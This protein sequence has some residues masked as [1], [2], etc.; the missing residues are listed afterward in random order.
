MALHLREFID[1][2]HEIPGDVTAQTGSEAW[3][4]SPDGRRTVHTTDRYV[5]DVDLF[6]PEPKWEIRSEIPSLL[7]LDHQS[8]LA[9]PWTDGWIMLAAEGLGLVIDST[10]EVRTEIGLPGRLGGLDVLGDLLAVT[11]SLGDHL[12]IYRLDPRQARAVT[13]VDPVREAAEVVP[14]A[15]QLEHVLLGQTGVQVFTAHGKFAHSCRLPARGQLA[16]MSATQ[17]VR[18]SGQVSDD[19]MWVRAGG[20]ALAVEAGFTS[21]LLDLERGSF[22]PHPLLP[23][24]VNAAALGSYRHV[25][26]SCSLKTVAAISAAA[27]TEWGTL[28]RVSGA[29]ESLLA[30][31][32]RGHGEVWVVTTHRTARIDAARLADHLRHTRWDRLHKVLLGSA[33]A[34]VHGLSLLSLQQGRG[35]WLRR[36]FQ[37]WIRAGEGTPVVS[38]LQWRGV[39]PEKFLELIDPLLEAASSSDVGEWAAVLEQLAEDPLDLAWNALESHTPR[40]V[41]I[42]LALTSRVMPSRAGRSLADSSAFRSLF[43]ELPREPQPDEGRLR[44]LRSAVLRAERQHWPDESVLALC[45]IEASAARRELR[46][47][48]RTGESPDARWLAAFGILATRPDDRAALEALTA[49]D[50]TDVV[51]HRLDWLGSL[52]PATPEIA[53]VASQFIGGHLTSEAIAVMARH[54]PGRSY[55]GLIGWIA[56]LT[57][58]CQRRD[59]SDKHAGG[60]DLIGQVTRLLSLSLPNDVTPCDGT[61]DEM[62]AMATLLLMLPGISPGNENLNLTGMTIVLALATGEW[63]KVASALQDDSKERAGRVLRLVLPGLMDRRPVLGAILALVARLATD[64]GRSLITSGERRRRSVVAAACPERGTRD[65]PTVPDAEACL[66]ILRRDEWPLSRLVVMLW[67][68]CVSRHPDTSAADALAEPGAMS[69]WEDM[70]WLA[71]PVMSRPVMLALVERRGTQRTPVWFD[72]YLE[73]SRMVADGEE[74]TLDVLAP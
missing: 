27:E 31:V 45:A 23:V 30:V 63:H 59:I 42:G 7:S 72:E 73:R 3:R 60:V 48:L 19:A 6:Q 37:L 39:D 46:K 28:C 67:R 54:D 50:M 5:A 29:R 11:S 38:E 58:L 43:V 40:R 21:R 8:A 56:A 17:P 64:P 15:G 51:A 25:S 69:P 32:P 26:S 1:L 71:A 68:A 2:E 41:R 62:A 12:G 22:E 61:V 70:V 13:L 55:I 36:L 34:P 33:G 24:H 35:R 53:R 57:I 66:G 52:V 4:S 16:P 9:V 14:G 18:L 47:I 10:G 49:G 20:R 74:G 44:S 65:D